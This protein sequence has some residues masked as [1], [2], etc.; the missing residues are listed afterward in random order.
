[1]KKQYRKLNL[2]QICNQVLKIIFKSM[3]KYNLFNLKQSKKNKLLKITRINLSN[4][5]TIN[6]N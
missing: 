2:N 5:L 1:M 3:L 4:R 6:I